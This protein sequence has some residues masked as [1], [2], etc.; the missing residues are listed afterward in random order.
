MADTIL[1]G[2]RLLVR[3]FPM[4]SIGRGDIVVVRS[5]LNRAESFVK[6][7]IGMPGGR[8]KLVNKVVYR[9]GSALTEPYATHKSAFM[10]AYRDNFPAGSPPAAQGAEDMLAHHLVN[11]E[12]VVPESKYFLLGDNRDDSWDSR[13][14]GFSRRE[15]VLGKPFLIYDSKQPPSDSGARPT[16][17][18]RIFKLL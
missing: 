10:D 15:D 14:W 3:R 12:V 4:P 16:R 6:R 9:N 7:V 8:I 13:Y 5:P 11:G 1:I 17:W 2:D 18:S